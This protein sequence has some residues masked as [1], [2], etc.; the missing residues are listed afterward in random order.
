MSNTRPSPSER[1]SFTY[2]A[3]A[4]TSGIADPDG[5][6]RK[7][8]PFGK[9]GRIPDLL[10]KQAALVGEGRDVSLSASAASGRA[11]GELVVRAFGG[12]Q[13]PRPPHAGAVEGTAVVVL[14][15][16]VIVVASPGRPTWKVHLEE[17]V[18]DLHGVH[19]ARIVGGA[20][21]EPHERERVG[22]D[23]VSRRL[24]ALSRRAVLDRDEARHRRRGVG[25]VG[26]RNAHVV[27]ID[28]DLPGELRP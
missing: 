9:V 28:A 7:Q 19:D 3:C 11:R 27:P 18:D 5:L 21:A 6:P 2:S 25:L 8:F 24:A 22:T 12:E 4:H 26:R 1:Q 16:A 15:V 10:G 17:R 20:Q 14:A 13:R 23:D